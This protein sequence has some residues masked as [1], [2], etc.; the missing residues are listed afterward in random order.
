MKVAV[1]TPHPPLQIENLKIPFYLDKNKKLE[2]QLQ[3]AQKC[4]S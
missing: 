3:I 4:M 1:A 2:K